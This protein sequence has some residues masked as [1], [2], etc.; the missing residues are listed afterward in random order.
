V[1]DPV[2]ELAVEDVEGAE[3][4]PLDEELIADAAKEAFDFSLGGGIAH[5][6]VPENATDAGA[7]EGD[8]LGGINRAVVD[9]QLLGDGPPRRGRSWRRRCGCVRGGFFPG[10]CRWRPE[11]ASSN[12][13]K[14]AS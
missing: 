5:G 1:F 10:R 4:E 14:A 8:L 3:I 7:D 11:R 6:G 9:E 2:G 12:R 13:P